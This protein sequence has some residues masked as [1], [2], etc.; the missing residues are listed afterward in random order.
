M[1]LQRDLFGEVV[2]TGD[3][4][5]KI[6]HIL[7][8]YIDARDSYHAVMFYFWR[9]FDGLDGVLDPGALEDFRRWFVT[10]ATSTKTL[11]NRAMECQRERSEL[12]AR[13]DVRAWRDKQ[14]TAGV[15]R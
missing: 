6:A 12:D 10:K 13:A 2:F 1:P 4:K 15:V 14:A 7:E 11:Q 9:D 5:D 3:T 8:E